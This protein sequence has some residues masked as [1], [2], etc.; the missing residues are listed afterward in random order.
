MVILKLCICVWQGETLARR[1]VGRCAAQGQWR[2]RG[3]GELRVKVAPGGRARLVMRARGN[4][5][6]LLNGNLWPE[7]KVTLM[8]GGK[9]RPLLLG[10]QR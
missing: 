10:A 3:R 1:D 9:A 5:R 8:D 2:E 6:L 7:M 4:L